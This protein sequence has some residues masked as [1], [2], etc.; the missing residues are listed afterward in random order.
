MC[1]IAR[2]RQHIETLIVEAITPFR[3]LDSAGEALLVDI[4]CAELG[5]RFLD[6]V[7]PAAIRTRCENVI[8]RLRRAR[9]ADQ[10]YVAMPAE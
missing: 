7:A 5:V 1:D 2:N 9:D 10:A 4:A 3:Y 6:F 8:A